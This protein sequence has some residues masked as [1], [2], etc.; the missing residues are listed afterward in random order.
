MSKLVDKCAITTCDK[1]KRTKGY[2][3][4]CYKMTLR[5]RTIE[6]ITV[7]RA[8]KKETIKRSPICEIEQCDGIHKAHGL[9]KPCYTL[10]KKGYSIEKIIEV[11]F[12]KSKRVNCKLPDCR[13]ITHAKGYCCNHYKMLLKGY[14]EQDMLESQG[15]YSQ[16]VT[17]SS[18]RTK[19]KNRVMRAIEKS[20]YNPKD[21]I[22]KIIKTK[23]YKDGCIR[24]DYIG[25]DRRRH[26][27]TI[28]L[29]YPES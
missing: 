29:A 4:A 1:D 24:I 5:G 13:Q 21:K 2:C 3:S 15:S 18:I 14:S 7:I 19:L 28:S 26:S 10:F 20:Y 22:C 9:C 12:N 25:T 8:T 23:I 16:L 27:Y 11:R 17:Q 6:E